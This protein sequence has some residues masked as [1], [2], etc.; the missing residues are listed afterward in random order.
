M[1]RTQQAAGKSLG[2]VLLICFG[3]V[4]GIASKI[5][6]YLATGIWSELILLYIWNLLVTGFDAYL[7][8]RFTRLTRL[9]TATIRSSTPVLG[10]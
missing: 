9:N 10:Q 7:V 5:T 4:L 1:L 8:V 3:Y 2:F 6:L